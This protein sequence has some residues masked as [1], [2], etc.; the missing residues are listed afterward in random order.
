MNHFTPIVFRDEQYLYFFYSNQ[1]LGG[2]KGDSAINEE[3]YF[4]NK[5]N[6]AGA[7]YA[8]KDGAI[9]L[10]ISIPKENT[11]ERKKKL[12]NIYN[13]GALDSMQV[14]LYRNVENCYYDRIREGTLQWRKN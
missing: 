8:S 6:C 13:S 2:Q 4:R 12:I 9:G 11:E 10:A 3:D 14:F 5:L 1:S 7:K